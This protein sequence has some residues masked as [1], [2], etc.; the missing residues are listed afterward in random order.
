[1]DAAAWVS[2]SVV[3]AVLAAVF[4]VTIYLKS[5]ASDRRFRSRNNTVP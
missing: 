3:V 5:L 4:G 1:M 2:L